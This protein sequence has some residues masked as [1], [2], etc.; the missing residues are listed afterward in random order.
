MCYLCMIQI[1]EGIE[2]TQHKCN[3][4]YII[5]KA[6]VNIVCNISPSESIVTK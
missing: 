2:K 4:T 1:T 6:L 3:I 5:G